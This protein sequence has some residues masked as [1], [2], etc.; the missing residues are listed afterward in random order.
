MSLRGGGAAPADSVRSAN[1]L[2]HE[3][4]PAAAAALEARFAAPPGVVEAELLRD[5]PGCLAPGGLSPDLVAEA[6]ASAAA[7]A[8]EAQAAAEAATAAA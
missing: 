6:A 3:L 1:I 2:G 4:L 7:Q 8:A 5:A